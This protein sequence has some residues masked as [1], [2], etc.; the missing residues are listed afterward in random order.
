MARM[1]ASGGWRS[2]AT[3]E[4]EERHGELERARWELGRM[5]KKREDGTG[6]LFIALGSH[7][8][9]RGRA[10]TTGEEV[11]RHRGVAA[12]IRCRILGASGG[13]SVEEVGRRGPA[14]GVSAR[15]EERAESAATWGDHGGG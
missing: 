11:G 5:G 4:R 6:K 7:G 10:A 15:V 3:A 8:R 9:G 1:A 12:A 13:R 14:M 2:P